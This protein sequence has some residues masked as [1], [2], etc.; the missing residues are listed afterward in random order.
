MDELK[1]IFWIVI[2]LI[3][4]FSRR[5]RKPEPPTRAD[6]PGDSGGDY[7]S[8]GQTKQL[9]FEELLEE[10]QGKKKMETA[11][12]AETLPDTYNRPSDRK[13]WERENYEDDI[14]EEKKELEDTNYD[15]RKHDKIYDVYEEAKKQAFFRPS[16][17]ET[18]KLE[19]TIVRF[20]QF[21]KYETEARR[22]LAEEYFKELKEPKGFR[23]AFIMS[24]ILKRRFWRPYLSSI[25]LLFVC[26]QRSKVDG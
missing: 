19:D 18:V 2:G 13:V 15:Y 11:K 4:L 5:K 22:N 7:E 23:K 24:E 10:I 3:Y 21:K 26:V 8:T 9:T 17:E 20:K 1:I 6:G 25:P 16:L 12:Q 14:E